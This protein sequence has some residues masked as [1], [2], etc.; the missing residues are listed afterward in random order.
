MRV[1]HVSQPVAEGGVARWVSLLARDQ[2]ARGWDVHVASPVVGS[3]RQD[4]HRLGCTHH[5]WRA[6]RSPGPASVVEVRRLARVIERVRPDVLHLHSS[7]AGLAGRLAVRGRTATIFQPHAWSF[8]AITGPMAS[9]AAGWERVAARWAHRVVCVSEHERQ[10]GLASGISSDRLEVIANGVDSEE[11]PYADGAARAGARAALEV[12]AT[13]PIAVCVAR[14]VRQKGQDQLISAWAA[15]RARVP[16]ALL[17]VV[18][19]GQE[20]ERF[21]ELTSSVPGATLVAER[22]D[23]AGVRAWMTA[24]DVVVFPSR[25]EGMALA[26]LE[27]AATGRSVV[28]TDTGGMA[29][30][31]GTGAAAGGAVV[32]LDDEAAVVARLAEAVADRL[33]ARVMADAEGR[34]G[35]RRVQEHFSLERALARTAQV[36]DE[37]YLRANGRAV[38]PAVID[39]RERDRSASV[40]GQ[41]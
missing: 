34:R 16:D 17:Y 30:I 31:L 10:V 28:A 22:Q 13:A 7:K 37:A 3:F 25:W 35:R 33:G 14:L 39:L 26:T 40:R 29:E 20:R 27:A 4:V 1:L 5:D 19:D 18:G 41:R 36:A 12:P 6:S 8:Q 32:P 38:A 21:A 2:T 11:W 23:A 15:V 9:A 24:A